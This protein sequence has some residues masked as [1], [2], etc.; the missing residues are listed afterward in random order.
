MAGWRAYLPAG[1]SRAINDDGSVVV[2]LLAVLYSRGVWGWRSGVL[3]VVHGE[4]RVQMVGWRAYLPTGRS[5]APNDDDHRRRFG[6]P[7]QRGGV[8]M[9]SGGPGGGPL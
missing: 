4:W 8:G 3:G 1:L 2:V 5:R 7:L 9:D 6:C